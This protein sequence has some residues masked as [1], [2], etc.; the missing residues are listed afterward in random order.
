MPG[1]RARARAARPRA[2]REPAHPRAAARALTHLITPLVMSRGFTGDEYAVMYSDRLVG[3]NPCTLVLSG[4]ALP[5]AVALKD[6]GEK[7][8]GFY[9]VGL[10]V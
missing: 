1:P 8:T 5:G 9:Q 4:T 6:T 7:D 10:R 3:G 2:S